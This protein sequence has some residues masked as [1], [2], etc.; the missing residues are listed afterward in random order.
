MDVAD[1]IALRVHSR[2]ELDYPSTCSRTASRLVM[3]HQRRQVPVPTLGIATP[4]A[5]E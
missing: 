2:H 5:A 4:V 3:L 1:F